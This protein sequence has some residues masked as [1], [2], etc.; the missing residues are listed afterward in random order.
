LK[1]L[2]TTTTHKLQK[3]E[4]R[5]NAFHLE[6]VTDDLLVMKPGET[7]YCRLDSDFYDQIMSRNV[8]F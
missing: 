8:A 7:C 5:D 3:N 1:D 2:P 6:K 4:L